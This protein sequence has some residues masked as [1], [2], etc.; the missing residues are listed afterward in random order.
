MQRSISVVF[1]LGAFLAGCAAS[2]RVNAPDVPATL[3]VPPKARL[4]QQLHGAGVQIYR[5]HAD[6]AQRF[7]WQLVAPD[8]DLSDH[9]G[10]KVG[11]HY[12]GPTWEASDGSRVVGEVM[13]RDNGP[14]ASAVPWLLLKAKATSGTG[15]FTQ[16]SFIQ[17][18]RTIG[19]TAPAVG[20]T[21][22]SAESEVRVAY[23][24]EYWFY[25]AKS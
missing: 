13:A 7:S 2:T 17:R 15:I 24:A 6:D 16:V 1:L 23:S 12:A 18:V 19:G 10:H 21:A 9:A 4:T 25:I 14:D 11:K 22:A 3:Q 8:A 5:C 20:C